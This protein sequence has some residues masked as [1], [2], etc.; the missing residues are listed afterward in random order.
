[1][2]IKE[3]GP[4]E[5]ISL[6]QIFSNRNLVAAFVLCF[7]SIYANFVIITW[8]PQFLIAERG[9]EGASVG[10]I[11]SLVPWASIAGALIFAR[12]NDKTGAAEKLVYLLVRLATLSVFSSVF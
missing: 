3:E 7:T 12:L 5:K 10:F 1:Q 9:F 8:L 6:K 11:A 2:E 4:K